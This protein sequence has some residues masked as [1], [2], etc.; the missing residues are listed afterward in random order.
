MSTTVR[1]E[2][3]VKADLDRFQGL[4]QSETGERLSQSQLLARLLRFAERRPW[5][6]FKDPAPAWKPPTKEQL[7]RFFDSLEDWG[8]DTDSSRIDEE[9]YGPPDEDP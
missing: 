1:V 7:D 5:D 8:V 3:E 9:L 4:V 2:D 6:F